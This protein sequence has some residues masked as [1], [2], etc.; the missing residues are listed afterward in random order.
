[1]Q[2][3]AAAT[4]ARCVAAAAVLLGLLHAAGDLAATALIGRYWA[5]V[6]LTSFALNIL[7]AS[8]LLRRTRLG[9]IRR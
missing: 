1:M 4:G 5:F 6:L 3:G 8:M 9:A 2:T 7:L